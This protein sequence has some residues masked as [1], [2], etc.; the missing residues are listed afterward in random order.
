MNNQ[1]NYKAASGYRALLIATIMIATCI[2]LMVLLIGGANA[3]PGGLE[4]GASRTDT[5]QAGATARGA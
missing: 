4:T 5:R 2:T 1:P 3:H